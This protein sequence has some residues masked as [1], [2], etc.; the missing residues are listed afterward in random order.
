MSILKAGFLNATVV[1]LF[2]NDYHPAVGDATSSYVEA[3][4]PGYGTWQ[5]VWGTITWL[6]DHVELQANTSVTWNATAPGGAPVYGYYVTD[7][8]NNLLWAERD[9]AAPVDMSGAGFSYTIIL[10]LTLDSVFS[11]G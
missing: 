2:K 5:I 11:S 1:H 7:T 10:K 9:P 6:G 8:S 4:F 3:N